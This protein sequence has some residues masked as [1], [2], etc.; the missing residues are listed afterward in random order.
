MTQKKENFKKVYIGE[1]KQ[2]VK[3]RLALYHSYVQNN[4]EATNQHFNLTGHSLAELIVTVIEQVRKRDT[5]V[6]GKGKNTILEDLTL[7]DGINK[8]YN[9][10]VQGGGICEY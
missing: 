8:K 6:E 9:I 3:C 2:M 7:H 5:I 1:M 4:V 10:W